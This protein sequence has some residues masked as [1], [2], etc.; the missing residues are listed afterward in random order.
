MD[1]L[2]L[3]AEPGGVSIGDEHFRRV[4]E[5]SPDGFVIFRSIRGPSGKIQDFECLYANPAAAATASLSAA[6]AKGKRLFASATSRR[7]QRMFHSCVA[8]VETG[9][10]WKGVFRHPRLGA[11]HW[12]RATIVRLEDG[13]AATFSDVTVA[14][15]AEKERARK[16]ALLESTAEGIFGLDLKGCCTFINR[17]A[18]EMLGYTPAE[19]LGKK[20]HQLVH[21]HR[22]DG[23]LYPPEECPVFQSLRS[24]ER[25]RLDDELLWRK[26][27]TSF[28]VEYSSS[29]IIWKGK[30]RGAVVA[31]T[32]ITTLKQAEA[33]LR[34]RARRQAAV[35]EMGQDALSGVDLRRR[36]E[37][38]GYL[39]RE[40][41]GVEYV[42]VLEFLPEGGALLRAGVG[43]PSGQVGTARVRLAEERQKDAWSLA[44]A[45]GG[46]EEGAEPLLE[47]SELLREAGIAS[48]MRVPISGGERPF[49]ILLA[50]TTQPRDFEDDDTSCL[51]SMANV[52]GAAVVRQQCERELKQLVR[53]QTAVAEFGFRALAGWDTMMLMR[54]ASTL[55]RET[56]G[57][58][59]TSFLE[60][61]PGGEEFVLRAGAGWEEEPVDQ[62]TVRIDPGNHAGYTLLS[63]EP[64]I[65]DD[66]RTETRFDPTPLL[67][68]ANI[69]SGVSVI[70]SGRD[71]PLG[72]LAAY[73][74]AQRSFR[75]NDI[76]LLQSLANLLAQAIERR[77]TEEVLRESERQFR[78][79]QKMEAVG[80]LAGGVA[81]DFNNLL[82]VI[83]GNAEMGMMETSP[84]DPL[85]DSLDEIIKAANR[86]AD[87][88]RQL[89]AF[90][91]RQVLRPKVLDLNATVSSTER[92]LRRVIGENVTLRLQLEPDLA[93][94]EADPGQIEQVLLNLVVNAQDAMPMGGTILLET[95]NVEVTP[96]GG[97]DY[98]YYI[99][100]GVYV[101]LALRD[102]GVGMDEATLSHLFEPFFSTKEKRKGTGLGLSTVYGIIKQSMGYVWA[103]S[104]SGVGSTFFILLPCATRGTETDDP[105][106]GA[107][108]RPP[109]L[110]T[111]LL[112]EDE[113]AVRSLTRRILERRG[114]LVLEASDV[115]EALGIRARYQ[116]PIHLVLTD[117]ILPGESGRELAE[118]LS[119]LSPE[120]KVLYMSG[121][122]DDVIAQ[123][124]VLEPGTHLLEKPFSHALLLRRVR[125][126]LDEGKQTP[127]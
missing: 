3:Q 30:T 15:R 65:A 103:H 13:F 39:V 99:K 31:F 115:D 119:V 37:N 89:L 108:T 17:A 121:Y 27:G 61:L 95:R 35:A 85:R 14:T 75:Q 84:L 42:A 111:V 126:V 55:L 86:A 123:H 78:Q 11:G 83:K 60:I 97:A 100:P 53:Q 44:E 28:P 112:V 76:D 49:G 50:A 2:S 51:Q 106:S 47:E 54:G 19:V 1:H 66:L 117:V 46:A 12:Y 32:D 93:P 77:Q 67:G 7:A 72:V 20:M 73:C 88:T 59:Y 113:S 80:R 125:E 5:S 107:V 79:A 120:S 101:Q 87:L 33:A 62:A 4:Q 90:S 70:V 48:A 104:Q 9:Q 16:I 63:G 122:T 8:V 58:D 57:V 36:L 81:H 82:T 24:G 102:T 116:G 34:L 91:R 25:L 96:D 26:E 68:D 71:R 74:T 10:P 105:R 23:S 56:L 94:I 110:E 43:W 41:L 38:A 18:A 114:Y 98:P 69:V 22:A 29:P 45:A 92:L 40:M 52:I 21:H 118:R 127:V 124:G 109:R 6:Y 64:V